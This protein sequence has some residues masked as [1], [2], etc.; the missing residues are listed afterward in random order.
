MTYFPATNDGRSKQT[1]LQRPRFL[2]LSEFGPRSLVYH[3]GRAF[4]VVAVRLAVGTAPAGE[5]RLITQTVRVCTTCGAAHFRDDLNSCQGCGASLGS[6]QVIPG[7][8]RIENVDTSPAERITANDEERQ[9][10][11]FE[12]QTTF[13]WAIRDGRI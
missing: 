4:R 7:L 2:G 5:A 6:S 1:Y 8:Y 10:Q 13:E 12:L 3:E 11:A 9:R